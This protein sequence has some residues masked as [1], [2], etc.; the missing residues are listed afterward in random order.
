M[1]QKVNMMLTLASSVTIFLMMI[2]SAIPPIATFCITF[3]TASDSKTLCDQTVD[4]IVESINV[5]DDE[6]YTPVYSFTYNNIIYSA[7]GAT[8]DTAPKFSVGTS[9]QIFIEPANPYHVYDPD[10]DLYNIRHK[11][12]IINLT[13]RGVIALAAVVV[14][15]IAVVRYRKNESGGN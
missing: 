7:P 13:I 3:P 5:S 4:A 11:E 9:K 10:F 2:L 15:V 6:A 12:L 8:I 14:S 1:N